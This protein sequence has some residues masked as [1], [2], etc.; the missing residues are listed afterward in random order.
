[1]RLKSSTKYFILISCITLLFCLA[2]GIDISPYLRGPAPYPPEWRWEYF[3]VN[4]ISKIY[5]PFFCIMLLTGLFWL[6]ETKNIFAKKTKL[7]LLILVVLSFLFQLSILYFSRSGISV[8][9]HRIISYDI[10]FTYYD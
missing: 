9:I 7:F 3:F 8:L 2:I 5:F 4:T 6:Q 1:M 10:L